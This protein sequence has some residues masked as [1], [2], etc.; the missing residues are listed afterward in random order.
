MKADKIMSLMPS[1]FDLVVVVLLLVGLFRG[2]KRGMS[3]E[4]LPVLQWLLI[5]VLGAHFYEPAGK[6]LSQASGMGILVCYLTVYV[7]I[8]LVIK[9]LFLVFKRF[10]GEKL[11]GSDLFGRMEY[12]FGIV[13]GG[14]RYMCMVLVALAL[15]NARLYTAAERK[16]MAKMQQ[17]NFGSIS[18]PTLDSIQAGVFEESFAGRQAK[19]YFGNPGGFPLLIKPTAPEDTFSKQREKGIGKKRERDLDSLMK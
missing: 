3:E 15:L 4:L 11:V 13:A 7:G 17:E 18:F 2:R 5:V 6:L 9:S 8:A 14:L 19:H 12:Y 16:A 10:V 1:W